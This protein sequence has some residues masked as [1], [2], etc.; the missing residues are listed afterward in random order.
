MDKDKFK[1]IGR[2]AFRHEG[3]SINAYWAELGTMQD[4][5]LLGTILQTLCDSQPGLFDKFKTLMREAM[6]EAVF[7]VTGIRPEWGGEESAPENERSGHA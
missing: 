6:G 4:A 5:M 1:P 2:L 3:E 7:Q